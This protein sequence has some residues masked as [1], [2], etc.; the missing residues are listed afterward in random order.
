MKLSDPFG[1]GRDD[2]QISDIRDAAILGIESDLKEMTMMQTTIS[3]RCLKFSQQ[4][5]TKNQKHLIQQPQSHEAMSSVH[6]NPNSNTSSSI[7]HAMGAG[8]IIL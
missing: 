4:R 7:Y 3:E 2:V 8:D 5:K 1:I 6:V